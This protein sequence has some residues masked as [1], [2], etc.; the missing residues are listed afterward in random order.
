LDYLKF[1][2]EELDRVSPV[3]DELENIETELAKL[4]A[5]DFLKGVTRGAKEVLYDGDDAVYEKLS[6]LAAQ[7][8]EAAER[9][10]T[11]AKSAETLVDAAASVEDIA[12]FLSKYERN[13]EGDPDRILE[14]EDR[15]ETLVTL[16]RKHGTDLAGVVELSTRFAGEIRTLESF[17]EAKT[18]AERKTADLQ[19]EADAFA[20]KLS[21]ERKKAAQT[22]SK[23]VIKELGDL[24]FA[25]AGFEVQL[26]ADKNLTRA[27]RDTAE[28]L[29]A[30]NPGEGAHP[31]QKT[32]SGG[33]LSR[34]MLAL[35]RA[36]AGVGPVGTYIFDEVDS[37]IGGPTASA[38]GRKLKEVSTCHQVI[39]ISHLPQI[40]GMADAH[41]F[42]SKKAEQGRT[43]SVIRRLEGAERV[44][45]LA[46]MLA[47]DKVTD[48]TRAAAKEL[49]G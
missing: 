3:P 23:A 10:G 21:K 19:K 48:K 35:K 27:G 26:D 22:L 1:Q 14:L 24:L 46:R 13:L 15:R 36:M 28:F 17:E 16:C 30:L 38:V 43:A 12:R 44:E 29:V 41:F 33:E 49:I 40:A 8:A 25:K 45:E 37:G 11:L 31:L 47:G 20:L 5:L 32:A 2:Q 39:C 42:V 4:K 18:E 6:V 34:L 9:D 7:L